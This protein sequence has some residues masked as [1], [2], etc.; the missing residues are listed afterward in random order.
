MSSV[1]GGSDEPAAAMNRWRQVMAAGV[2]VTT[3]AGCGPTIFSLPRPGGSVAG[4]SY[5][6]TARFTDALNLPDGAH[7]RVGGVEVGRVEKISTRDYLADVLMRIPRKVVLTDQ[8]TAQLRLTTP[9]GEGFVDIDPGKGTKQLGAGAVIEPAATNT[10]ATVEDM[11]AA[12]SV[13]ITGGGLGQLRTIAVELNKVIDGKHGDPRVLLKSLNDTLSAFNSRT[14]DIDKTLAA[15]DSLSGTLVNRQGTLNAALRD[16]APAAKLLAEQTDKFSQLLAR[17][18][19]LGK[20]GDRIVKAT[21]DDM[22]AA[23]KSAQPVLDALISVSTDIGPT[24]SEL[25]AFGK[26]FDRA[27]PGD[28]LSGDVQISPS[29]VGAGTTA[30]PGPD[31]SLHQMMRG[32]R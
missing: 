5:E 12:A 10:A 18:V 16:T 1:P 27:T 2:A 9:L 31:L 13:L 29:S 21:R 15:L 11:L 14:A 32:R 8:A 6:I 26:F 25:V 3:L 4:P 17:V 22:V 19:A 20:V 7:V 24:L 23:L 28:Y 30:S